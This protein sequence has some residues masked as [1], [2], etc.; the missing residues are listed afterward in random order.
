MARLILDAQNIENAVFDPQPAGEIP[1][2][3]R[4]FG[5]VPSV[6]KLRPG[7][8]ILVSPCKPGLSTHFIRNYQQKLFS[9]RDSRWTHA[10]VHIDNGVIVEATPGRGVCVSHIYDYASDHCILSRRFDSISDEQ[11]LKIALQACLKI[12]RK[13]DSFAMWQ[14]MRSHLSHWMN[15]NYISNRHLICSQL[16]LDSFLLG[17]DKQIKNVPIDG[18]V[19][20]AH[21]AA[22]SEFS[23]LAMD[24]IELR[25]D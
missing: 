16:Y 2:K 11:R 14:F 25:T 17:A 6:L 4:K 3:I 1:S 5:Y 24:W 18:H 19:T 15:K 22:A 10:V 20:P 21:L 23:D 7:D 13:Y 9:E 8:L 12:G